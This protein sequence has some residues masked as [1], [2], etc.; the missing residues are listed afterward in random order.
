MSTLEYQIPPPIELKRKHRV[1]NI[2]NNQPEKLMVF[3]NTL[4][5][6]LS[7]ALGKKVE[8]K[9]EFEPIKPGDVH[10]TY[11][12]TNELEEL[13]G[14]KPKTGIGEGLTKFSVW[15]IKTREYYL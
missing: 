11:A 9:K 5:E 10:K 1:L 12:S 3:I 6:C 8:F 15:Y 4:E 2:G 14:F 13:V 7:N